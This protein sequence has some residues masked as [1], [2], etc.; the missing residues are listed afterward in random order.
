MTDKQ[1][2]N[3][4]TN[5]EDNLDDGSVPDVSFQGGTLS[6]SNVET[7]LLHDERK[8]TAPTS[9]PLNNVNNANFVRG[10]PKSAPL[11]PVVQDG[12]YASKMGR[13]ESAVLE[14]KKATIKDDM[15]GEVH[16]VWLLTEIDHWDNE[17]ERLIIVTSNSLLLVKYDFVAGAVR[18]FQRINH[19]AVDALQIGVFSYPQKSLVSPRDGTGLRIIWSH[20][21]QPTFMERWNPFCSTIPWL[22]LTSHP[23]E[24]SG[25]REAETYQIDPFKNAYIQAINN[26][27]IKQNQA[28]NN[29]SSS[30]VTIV[31]APIEC[32]VMLGLASTVHNQSRLGFYRERGGV[33]F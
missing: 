27:R 6:L 11:S 15:D 19:I 17:K 29:V 18:Q 30:P 21:R 10:R 22:T 33:S 20:G 3:G 25:T 24:H 8:P 12:F 14:C 13:L 31:D 7:N 28:L 4:N 23:L 2:P 26:W 9:L 16:G 32:D 5:I 1:E